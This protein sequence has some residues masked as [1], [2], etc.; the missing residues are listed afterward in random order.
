MLSRTDTT[1]DLLVLELVL[2]GL[3]AGIGALVLLVLAPV[4]A[5]AEDDVLADG[6]GVSGRAV[7]VLGALTEL[8]PCFAVGDAGVHGLLV[9]GVADAAGRLDFVAVLVDAV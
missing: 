4:N 2:H 3:C 8:A 6:G 7:G 1:L 5:G 9:G